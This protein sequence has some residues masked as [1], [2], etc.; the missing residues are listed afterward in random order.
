[1]K[2]AELRFPGSDKNIQTLTVKLAGK[3]RLS[4][5]VVVVLKEHVNYISQDAL[6]RANAIPP[7]VVVVLGNWSPGYLE[8]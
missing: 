1:M 7:L 8:T 4:D 6:H 3:L 2:G 5:S